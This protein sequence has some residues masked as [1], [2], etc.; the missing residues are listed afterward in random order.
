VE[1]IRFLRLTDFTAAAFFRLRSADGAEAAGLGRRTAAPR[2]GK[3]PP[4]AMAGT[5]GLEVEEE[6]AGDW[7]GPGGVGD[8][9]RSCSHWREGPQN[10]GHVCML[11]H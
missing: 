6:P 5:L 9:A 11:M 8:L 2:R 3:P 10:G 7:V 4:C 1:R